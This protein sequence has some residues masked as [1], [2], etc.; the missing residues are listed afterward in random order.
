MPLEHALGTK[1]VSHDQQ[2]HVAVLVWFAISARAKENDLLW[3]KSRHN[4][5]DNVLQ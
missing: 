3:I 2:V 5:L 4:L 1:R